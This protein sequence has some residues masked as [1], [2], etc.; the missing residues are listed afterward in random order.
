MKKYG[1]ILMILAFL[2]LC[3]INNQA[4]QAKPS[5]AIRAQQAPAGGTSPAT[6]S[7]QPEVSLEGN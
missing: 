3:C 2:A 4:Q 7:A 6:S 1:M 5:P